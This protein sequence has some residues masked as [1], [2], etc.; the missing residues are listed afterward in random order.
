MTLQFNEDGL[1]AAMQEFV[2][3]TIDPDV[4]ISSL[5]PDS[6]SS[7]KTAVAAILQAY[8]GGCAMGEYFDPSFA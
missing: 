4:P 7:A 8:E 6:Y 2:R 1:K 5:A 3:Q